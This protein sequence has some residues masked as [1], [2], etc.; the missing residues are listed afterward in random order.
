MENE[1]VQQ[2]STSQEPVAQ[3]ST[4]EVQA[5]SKDSSN[6]AM[7]CHILGILTGFVGPLIIWLI[8]KDSDKFVDDQG[9]EAL[10][11]QITIAILC[12]ILVISVIGYFLMPVVL[13][14][15][16]IFC[17]MGAVSA[18]S[19]KAYKYPICLRLLK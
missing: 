14:L 13:I 19:G 12:V 11:F 1:T 16:L 15:N 4:K 2:E 3:E 5:V 17:I 9:K 8:K 6:L 7:L 18:S 10:N